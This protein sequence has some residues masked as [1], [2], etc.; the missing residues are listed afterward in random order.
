[1]GPAATAALQSLAALSA[2]GYLRVQAAGMTG[3]IRLIKLAPALLLAAGLSD[4]PLLLVGFVF[5][6]LGDLLLLDKAR[7]FLAGLA[8]FLVGHG[9]VISGL[10]ASGTPTGLALGLTAPLGIAMVVLLWPALRGPLR[11]A[12]PIYAATLMM[13]VWAATARSPLATVGAVVFLA[14][15]AL[16]AWEHFR[17]PIPGGHTG[18][19][20]TYYAAIGL[21]AAG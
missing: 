17:R 21:I 5:Y 8:A 4:R 18:V 10:L 9:L 16:L 19:L 7:W 11:V 15:D 2:F 1:M 14:S 12:V 6:A 20:V 13:L 3:P